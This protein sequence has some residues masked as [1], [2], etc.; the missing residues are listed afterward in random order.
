MTPLAD[1][2][3]RLVSENG[4]TEL[5]YLLIFVVLRPLGF[6]N[7]FTVLHWGLGRSRLMRISIGVA[8]GLPMLG[9]D[10]GAMEVIIQ[11]SPYIQIAS[12]AVIEISIGYGLGFLSSLPF[13]AL[14]Y[15]GAITDTFRGESDS[16]LIDANDE[17]LPSFGLL[18]IVIAFSAFFASGGFWDLIGNLYKTYR[19]W[20]LGN[21]NIAL[22]ADSVVVI[23]DILTDILIQSFTIAVPLLA[24]MAFLLFGISLGSRIA[25]RFQLDGL[26]FMTKNLA[27]VCLLPILAWIVWIY[28]ADIADSVVISLDILLRLTE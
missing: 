8:L 14:Q 27:A 17:P 26:I 28:C 1:D 20:P 11:D 21:V 25:V 13:L 12:I 9:Q 19:I 16:G 2:I 23:F 10:F 22:S 18:Y 5:Y 6:L 4:S 7:G 15:A 24:I 3:A